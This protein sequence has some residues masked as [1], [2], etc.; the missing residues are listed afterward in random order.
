VVPLS[1]LAPRGPSAPACT[2]NMMSIIDEVQM[3]ERELAREREWVRECIGVHLCMCESERERG[4]EGEGER[5]RYTWQRQNKM[6]V[7]VKQKIG[8]VAAGRRKATVSNSSSC[9]VP[10]CACAR[11]SRPHART[12]SSFTLPA[13]PSLLTLSVT[14]QQQKSHEHEL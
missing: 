8:A 6:R 11:L 1:P 9:C 13:P 14:H 10:A 3:H 4:R 2:C 12:H 7:D 5:E